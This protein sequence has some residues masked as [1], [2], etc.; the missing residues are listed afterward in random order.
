[1]SP[2]FWYG[3]VLSAAL[4]IVGIAVSV[5]S[6]DIRSYV[7]IW[8]RDRRLR[9]TQLRIR[10]L[11]RDLEV[12]ERYLR[13]PGSANA[14]F[15]SG[16]FSLIEFAL[17]VTLFAIVASST[18]IALLRAVGAIAMTFF[19]LAM[20]G[21]VAFARRRAEMLVDAEESSSRIKAELAAAQKS[22]AAESA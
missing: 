17:L 19:V 11:E 9:G 16:L 12:L 15:W 2:E 1:M 6:S 5:F 21:F 3:A 10:K 7:G 13:L 8:R 22:L 18:E 14:F 20:F 4:F